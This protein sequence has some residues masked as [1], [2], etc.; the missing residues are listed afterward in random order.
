M[1]L[2]RLYWLFRQQRNAHARPPIVG[3]RGC[4]VR[5]CI[6]KQRLP[7]VLTRNLKQEAVGL[8]VYP[9]NLIKLLLLFAQLQIVVGNA[10]GK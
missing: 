3:L 5:L 8:Y 10:Q 1:R 6:T 4:I 2:H 9:F 7:F